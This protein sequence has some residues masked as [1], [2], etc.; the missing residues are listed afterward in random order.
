MTASGRAGV[1]RRRRRTRRHSIGAELFI[2]AF[3]VY[4]L[5]PLFWLL[6]SSTKST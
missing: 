3:S 6:V 5:L 4:F 1:R 2:L